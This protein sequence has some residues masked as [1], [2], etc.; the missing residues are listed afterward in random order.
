[1]LH[2]VILEQTMTLT[3]PSKADLIELARQLETYLNLAV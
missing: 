2:G 3:S 1:V